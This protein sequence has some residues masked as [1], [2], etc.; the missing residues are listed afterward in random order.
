MILSTATAERSLNSSSELRYCTKRLSFWICVAYR[1]QFFVPVCVC[2]CVCVCVWVCGCVWVGGGGAITGHWVLP[3]GQNPEYSR[4][5]SGT[6]SG[7][8]VPI[9]M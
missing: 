7:I 9:L 1:V 5:E 8:T 4:Q 3:R 2:V 6:I